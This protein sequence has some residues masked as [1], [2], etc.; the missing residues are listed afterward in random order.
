MIRDP[1]VCKSI[2]RD[3]SYLPSFTRWRLFCNI[4]V[5]KTTTVIRKKFQ[6]H[7]KP[8]LPTISSFSLDLGS[9]LTLGTKWIGISANK[10]CIFLFLQFFRSCL[11]YC[12]ANRESQ[13]S[14]QRLQ[15]FNLCSELKKLAKISLYSKFAKTRNNH[16]ALQSL[17]RFDLGSLRERPSFEGRKG[18]RSWEEWKYE[19]Q[20]EIGT[21][22]PNVWALTFL[23]FQ[24]SLVSSVWSNFL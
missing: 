9:V 16:A 17:H 1:R 3:D 2:F 11:F 4:N 12:L 7:K 20:A 8:W 14:S 19:R 22:L 6:K 15:S 10:A 13:N 5:T 18:Q 21:R 24:G 23:P